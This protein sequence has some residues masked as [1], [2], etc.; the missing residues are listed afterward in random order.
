[1]VEYEAKDN[2]KIVEK[3]K[4]YGKNSGKPLTRYQAA[5]N[6]A[7]MDIAKEDPV[8]VLDRGLSKFL[9]G[10]FLNC[11]SNLVAFIEHLQYCLEVT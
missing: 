7:A 6:E 3:A 4:I 8:V 10:V 11:N 5:K 9:R 1:M 2:M